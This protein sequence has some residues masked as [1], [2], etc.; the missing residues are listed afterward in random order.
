MIS[1]RIDRLLENVDSNYASVL[2]AAKR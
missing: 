1:P 2:V